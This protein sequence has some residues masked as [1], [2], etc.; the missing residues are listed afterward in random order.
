M[1]RNQGQ[2][3][4]GKALKPSRNQVIDQLRRITELV[5]SNAPKQANLLTIIVESTLKGRTISEAELGEK[6][7][8]GAF[9]GDSHKERA[10]VSIV[11][12]KIRQFYEGPGNNDLIRIVL[13]PGPPYTAEFSFHD[14]AKTIRLYH[15]ALAY[16]KG[17]QLR[18]LYGAQRLLDHALWA[19][20]SSPDEIE[21]IIFEWISTVLKVALTEGVFWPEH[22]KGKEMFKF[23]LDRA[24]RVTSSLK[25]SVELR[26][27]QGALY[28]L[29]LDRKSATA[30]FG[31]ALNMDASRTKRHPWY[32]AYLMAEGKRA[33]AL[34]IIDVCR[35]DEPDNAEL[36]FVQ[37]LFRYLTQG[38]TEQLFEAVGMT[39]NIDF[40][41]MSVLQAL[42]W[43]EA[44][45]HESIPDLLLDVKLTRDREW[46]GF[47]N[48]EKLTN[49]PMPDLFIGLRVAAMVNARKIQ[50]ARKAM[51][52]S[53]RLIGVSSLQM[54]IGS[55]ALGKTEQAIID[56][57]QAYSR[58]SPLLNWLH[59]MPMF[60]ALK[61]HPRFQR[62]MNEIAGRA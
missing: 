35:A 49:A 27:L 12:G 13:P 31:M 1:K 14:G 34:Q 39:S 25:D 51:S 56:L 30:E 47:C 26:I 38:E 42:V 62:L 44:G 57:E 11:R 50:S 43:V 2:S 54:A 61:A 21:D 48:S 18:F 55:L 5:F 40:E 24:F 32:A 6:L 10:S 19:W 46:R 41:L 37:I 16:R 7:E 3:D 8:P 20:Q 59:L 15:Q 9:R 33:A 45:Y 28:L 58:R 17:G 22:V 36:I 53:G 4:G 52:S 29:K 60:R 23:D